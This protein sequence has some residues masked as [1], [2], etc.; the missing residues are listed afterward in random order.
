MSHAQ[1][2][3][4]PLHPDSSLSPPKLAKMRKLSTQELI[5]C[6]QPGQSES[7][8]ARPDGTML[9]GHHRIKV[10]RERNVNVDSLPR[11]I[12]VPDPPP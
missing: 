2:P 1:P 9:N 6:L 4:V 3:L 8:K 12:V 7:L 11:E 5:D 10:L